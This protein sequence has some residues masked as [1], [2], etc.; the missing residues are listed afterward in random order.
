MARETDGQFLASQDNLSAFQ[1]M[2]EKVICGSKTDPR[3][4]RTEFCCC[5]E[6]VEQREETAAPR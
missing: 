1:A 2:L 5:Q 3:I 4:T 6:Y